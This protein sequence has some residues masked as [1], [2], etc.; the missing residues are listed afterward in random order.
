MGRYSH[1]VSGLEIASLCFVAYSSFMRLPFE[2]PV[3]AAMRVPLAQVQLSPC[4][5]SSWVTPVLQPS[6][7]SREPAL[8]ERAVAR[9]LSTRRYELLAGRAVWLAAQRNQAAEIEALVY[10]LEDRVAAAVALF[11]MNRR[12]ELSLIEEAQVMA[13]LI[14]AH[15]FR[16]REIGEMLGRHQSTVAHTVR[17]LERLAPAVVDRVSQGRLSLGHAKALMTVPKAEQGAWLERTLAGAW[18]VQT[19]MQQIKQPSA[20]AD[21]D[22]TRLEQE[23]TE[24]I[25]CTVKIEHSPDGRGSIRVAYFSLAEA[26]GVI[27]RLRMRPAP[28]SDLW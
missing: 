23:L 21:V 5:P 26:E 14:S 19:L 12:A 27:A 13:H 10:V 25:G 22:L 15:R 9:M 18:S 16:Q 6:E 24:E 3:A 7:T 1:A 20:A 17:L 28:E 2:L 4:L 11:E 8:A